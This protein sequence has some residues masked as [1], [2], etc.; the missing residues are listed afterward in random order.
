EL[1]ALLQGGITFPIFRNDP[2]NISL[3][4]CGPAPEA[5]S[6]SQFINEHGIGCQTLN[7]NVLDLYAP[8]WQA[9][10]DIVFDQIRNRTLR[11]R[12]INVTPITFDLTIPIS[13]VH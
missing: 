10:R 3:F 8:Q 4:C 9:P 1:N 11:G 2:L 12:N 6:F 5:V 13:A 7:F